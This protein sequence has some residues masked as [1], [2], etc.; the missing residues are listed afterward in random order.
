MV[1]TI[2]RQAYVFTNPAAFRLRHC[3]APRLGQP[4]DLLWHLHE[5][6]QHQATKYDPKRG[7]LLNARITHPLD[8]IRPVDRANP[9]NALAGKQLGAWLRVVDDTDIVHH[10][11][12]DD[13]HARLAAEGVAPS[14]DGR[15]YSTPVVSGWP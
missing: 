2:I 5:T 3:L 6:C 8:L 12:L 15:S 4:P 11:R 10:A 1:L 13:A 14:V 7:P 9:L